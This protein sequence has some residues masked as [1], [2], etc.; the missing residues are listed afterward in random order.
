MPSKSVYQ[1]DDCDVDDTSILSDVEKFLCDRYKP[2]Y[3]PRIRHFSLGRMAKSE[4]RIIER[5]TNMIFSP[6]PTARTNFQNDH[7]CHRGLNLRI[8]LDKENKLTRMTCLCPLNY[9]GNQCQYQNQ[10]VSLTLQFRSY[11]DSRQTSF[12]V[13]ITLIDDSD[14]R[15]VHSYEQLTYIPIP[16]CKTK[17]NIDLIYSI[18]P[19]NP[20]RTYSIHIDVYDKLSLS[21]RGSL[22]IPLSFP[23]LPVQRI[24][25]ILP[26]PYIGN[27]W[28]YCSNNKCNHGE[29]IHYFDDP[30]H[31][32]F[33]KCEKGW[34]GRYCTI[35]CNCTCSSDSLCVGIS[36]NNRSICVCP[37]YK[38]GSRCFL[39]D[40]VCQSTNST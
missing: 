3:E 20:S 18:R 35:P 24:T 23:F 27:D 22:L 30:K 8:W 32:T 29:C 13:I 4:Q 40:Q 7:H 31:T 34:T 38:W 26:I 33:C 15:T 10:R 6:A 16:N 39:H 11:S 1:S 36:A 17:Y 25:L 37:M 28:K 12:T 5:D 21:Y 2:L 9:Y 19:K 14:Q